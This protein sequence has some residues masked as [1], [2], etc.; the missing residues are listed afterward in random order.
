MDK[1]IKMKYPEY[2]KEFKCIGGACEDSCCV[3]WDIDIDKITFKEYYKVKNPEM[4]KMFQKNVHNNEHC[5]SEDV[6][7]GKVKLKA[8]KRCP[9][10]DGDN[11]CKIYSNIGE[12]YLS[13]VCTSFPRIINKIDGYHEM[14]LDFACPE[15][16][17]LILLKEEGIKFVENDEVLGKHII[18]TE[19]ETQSKEFNE[20]PIKYFEKIRDLSIKIIQNRNFSLNERLYKLG[21]FINELEDE[22]EES[23]ETLDKFIEKYDINSIIEKDIESILYEDEE[24]KMKYIMQIDFFKKMI[25]LLNVD[26]DVDSIKFK[27]YT[28]EVV[29]GFKINEEN[30]LMKNKET[31]IKAFEDY[32]ENFIK[33]NSYMF[34]NYLV[35]FIY[36]NLFPFSEKGSIFDSYMMLLTRYAFI[37]FY[38]V[39]GQLFGKEESKENVV[40]LIQTFSKTIDHHKTYLRS[41]LRYIKD[42]DFDNIEFAKMFL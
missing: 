36:K 12:E 40:R 29:E 2:F 19:V 10:L 22:I 14:S 18:S 39:G 23:F 21:V 6:D 3:G 27:E 31:Y 37:R 17:R 4:K 7:Y 9:F 41:S 38:L 20:S 24:N 1:S 33:D 34:E 11:Y 13:N 28:N 30:N 35:N 8:D 42:K 25:S 5:S 16:S 15:A 26:T 32:E